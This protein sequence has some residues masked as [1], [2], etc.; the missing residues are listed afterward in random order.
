MPSSATSSDAKRQE[1]I[2]VFIDGSN[3]YHVLGEVCGRHDL[4][5]GKFA[6]KISG[7]RDL[8]RTYYYNIRQD[9][10]RDPNVATEQG[11]FLQ[12][13]YDTPYL[14]V[15][16]GVSK[17]H[18]ETMVEKGVD[19]FMA[20]DLVAFAFMDLYD[21]AIVVSGDGDFFPAIQTA[22]NQGKHVEVAAFDNNLSGEASNVADAVIKLNKTYFTGLWSDRRR[23]ASTTSSTPTRRTR[24]TRGSSSSG[25]TV[26]PEP[27]ATEEPATAESGNGRRT[28]RRRTSTSRSTSRTAGSRTTTRR[29]TPTRRTAAETADSAPETNSAPVTDSAPEST[30]DR[31]PEPSRVASNGAGA[32]DEDTE[33]RRPV[34]RTPARRRVGARSTAGNGNGDDSTPT[35]PRPPA[36]RRRTRS[37]SDGDGPAN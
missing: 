9:S 24:T 36:L 15:R 2:M 29:R 37:S 11:K 17:R 25:R 35:P 26:T 8:V 31:A 16:M 20:T 34:R 3:L 12:T 6:E 21:T 14:E 27:E 7:D 4:N 28:T 18:G 33:S 32:S 19:V 10:E 1:R 5:F 13:M 30:P 23:R 22:K